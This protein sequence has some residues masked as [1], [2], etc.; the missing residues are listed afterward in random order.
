MYIC[1][2]K[3]N[4]N[5]KTLNK[6]RT[7]KELRTEIEKLQQE[8]HKVV[9]LEKQEKEQLLKTKFSQVSTI[10]SFESDGII[11]WD[12]TYN[13]FHNGLDFDFDTP[14]GERDLDNRRS[15][16]FEMEEQGL[17]CVTEY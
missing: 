4:N 2:I 13:V 6:M 11:E 8:L 17:C 12:T 3:I 1:T 14:L 5:F 10:D 15:L 7:S 9:T 16:L